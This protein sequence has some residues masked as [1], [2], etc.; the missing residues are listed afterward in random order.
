MSDRNPYFFKS[1]LSAAKFRQI[2]RYFALDL[3]ASDAAELTG[4]SVRSVNDIDLRLRRRL[5]E[6]C[7]KVSP[8]S[9]PLAADES[10]FGPRRV[11]GKRGRGALGKT[12]VFGLLKRNGCVY[13]ESVPNASKA[14]LQAI[15]RGK[16]QLKASSTPMAG[17]VM[18]AWSIWAL[19]NI[20][21]CITGIMNLSPGTNRSTASSH[22]G[23]MP[24][25]ACRNSMAFLNTPSNGI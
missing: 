20:S 17:V 14:T 13:T 19:T 1:K 12:I 7:A 9:G 21:G 5:A 2:L 6:E 15:I 11:R 8:F 22:S 3:T 24:N 25:D 23:A 10:Y 16:A 18:M 4:I